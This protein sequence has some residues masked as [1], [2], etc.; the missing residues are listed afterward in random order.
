MADK[1]PEIFYDATGTVDGEF[2][3][4]RPFELDGYIYATDQRIVVRKPDEDRFGIHPLLGCPAVNTMPW[5]Y[6]DSLSPKNVS[7]HPLPD[8][9]FRQP[10]A[11][12]CTLGGFFQKPANPECSKCGGAGHYDVDTNVTEVGPA[13]IANCY[14]EILR[15]SKV[16]VVYIPLGVENKKAFQIYFMRGDFEGM[17]GNAHPPDFP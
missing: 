1:L 17:V 9:C 8:E 13:F 7:V 15:K 5:D 11:C 6:F 14:A 16:N 4:F 3:M 2:Q 12:K 10:K